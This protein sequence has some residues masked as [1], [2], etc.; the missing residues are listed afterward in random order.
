MFGDNNEASKGKVETILGNGTNLEGDLNTG[1]SV[2]IEGKIVGSIKA[3]GDLFVGENG[4]VKD[5]VEARSVV[6][7]GKVEGHVRALEKL[8][9]LA[10]GKLSGDI[11]AASL[12]IE[13][14]AVFVG[15][16]KP[17]EKGPKKKSESNNKKK[18][19]DDQKKN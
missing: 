5:D 18:K 17:L 16:S 11:Q 10:S 7:A 13:E 8:E 3:D 19:K 1:G 14:G 6:I 9:I 4:Y 2:R 15:S 12:K